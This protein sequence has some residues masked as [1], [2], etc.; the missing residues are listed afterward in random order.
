MYLVHIYDWQNTV[1]FYRWGMV[2]RSSCANVILHRAYME[3]GGSKM[4]LFE[5]H[6]LRTAVTDIEKFGGGDVAVS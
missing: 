5:L 6:N 1:V 3:S 2:G 4:S